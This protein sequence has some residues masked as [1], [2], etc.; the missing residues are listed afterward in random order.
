MSGPSFVR[1]GTST[2]V[3][4][5]RQYATIGNNTA[6]Y[7]QFYVKGGS[8]GSFRVKNG[9]AQIYVA[10]IDK[11]TVNTTTWDLVQA[12]V[13][14]TGAGYLDF[15]FNNNAGSVSNP[16]RWFDLD[17][18]TVARGPGARWGWR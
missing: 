2:T 17:G 14:N 1:I 3:G 13:P 7:I 16:G 5:I 18:F 9:A 15:I 6:L 8:Y 12:Y 11:R 10:Q 4:E